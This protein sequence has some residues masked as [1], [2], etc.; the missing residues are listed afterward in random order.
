MAAVLIAGGHRG[1]CSF[2]GHSFHSLSYLN[3]EKHQTPGLSVLGLTTTFAFFRNFANWWVSRHIEFRRAGAAQA[4]MQGMI[5]ARRASG[6]PGRCF[7]FAA[8]GNNDSGE[9]FYV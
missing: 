6:S 7:A 2:P 9:A 1:K 3:K 8:D 5:Y 4:V